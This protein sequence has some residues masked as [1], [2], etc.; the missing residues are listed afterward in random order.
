MSSNSSINL[1][2]NNND[3]MFYSRNKRLIKAVIDQAHDAIHQ[4]EENAE[5]S[6]NYRM[7][8]APIDIPV[9]F[10]EMNTD[11]EYATY[12]LSNIVRY[13]LE[14][15]GYSLTP[16]M[17]DRSFH[18]SWSLQSESGTP[19]SFSSRRT[20]NFRS[21][22]NKL[23]NLQS[24]LFNEFINGEDH[25][26]EEYQVDTE[27]PYALSTSDIDRQELFISNKLDSYR[28]AGF[29]VIEGNGGD[30]HKVTIAW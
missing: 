17:P 16:L 10:G 5:N 23:N 11:F 25:P 7:Q 1:H 19:A 20:S 26:G 27:I 8:I 24:L 13:Q 2:I 9:D 29:Q 4:S 28:E 12:L 15:E 21:L 18:I 14:Q 30:H 22:Q 6:V 3:A